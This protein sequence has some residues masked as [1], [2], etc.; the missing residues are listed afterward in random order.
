MPSYIQGADSTPEIF[1]DGSEWPFVTEDAIEKESSNGNQMIELKVRV[2]GPNGEKK[3]LLYDFLVFTPG[4]Y[5]K[6]DEYRE[7]TGEKLVPGK[8]V[9]FEAEDC[10]DR[11]GRLIVTIDNYQGRER[12]K[13]SYYVTD[14]VRAT[15]TTN[16]VAPLAAS[17]NE[18]G[19]PID[20]PF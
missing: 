12:N 3:S 9:A 13:V 10:I 6:I 15:K 7:A 4:G 1:P 14:H 20:V 2:L 19:E 16:K 8:E 17:K 11:H 5:R 18:L